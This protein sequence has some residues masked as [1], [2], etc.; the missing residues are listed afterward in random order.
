MRLTISD[1]QPLFPSKCLSVKSLNP[2]YDST[3][4]VY[5]VETEKGHFVIKIL[6]DTNNNVFWRGLHLLFEATHLASI[7][8][9]PNLSDFLNKLNSI[10][11]P[12]VIKAEASS[13]NPIH[14]PYVIFEKMSGIPIPHDSEIAYELSNDSDVALQLGEF[15]NKVHRQ[16]FDYF[17]DIA[18]KGLPLNQFPEKFKETIQKLA[19]TRKALQDKEVQQMLP[20]FLKLASTM[21]PPT[22][23]GLIQ[24]D[25]WPTQ[26]LASK[27]RHL[28]SLI[29]IESYVV[30]PIELELV[31]VELWI[32]HHEKFKEAYLSTGA[33]WPDL[34]EQRELYRYFLY[35]LY[36]CPEQ[37]LKACIESKGKFA[38][39]DT[40]RS[41]MNAPRPRPSGYSSPYGPT[42]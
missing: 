32:G 9:Q 4:D 37:G 26:F 3:N 21:K 20:Y 12:K 11:V 22:K 6:R 34:E 30:G 38:A 36:D 40:P 27:E 7:H 13:K 23:A 31:L 41:R 39:Y 29:D 28:S 18:G 5:A 10:P 14:R 25:L 35:L 24:L 8:N 1:L 42:H 19:T 33:K 17:G 15:L 2:G 16:A